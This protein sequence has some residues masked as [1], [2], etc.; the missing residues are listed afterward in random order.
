METEAAAN[1]NYNNMSTMDIDFFDEALLQLLANDDAN[2]FT[3]HA[4]QNGE[5]YHLHQI[6]NQQKQK[7]DVTTTTK[8]IHPHSIV[9]TVVSCGCETEDCSHSTITTVSTNAMTASGK[10]RS[11]EDFDEEQEED[12]ERQEDGEEKIAVLTDQQKAIG[13]RERNREHAKR[14]RK[15]KKVYVDTLQQNI[16][17]L[18]QENEKLR[19]AMTHHFGS[20]YVEEIL[21]SSMSFSSN[22]VGSS[23]M[24]PSITPT[25]HQLTYHQGYGGELSLKSISPTFTTATTTSTTTDN[26][27]PVVNLSSV[28]GIKHN[29]QPT[30]VTSTATTTTASPNTHQKQKEISVIEHTLNEINNNNIAYK[31]RLH[32]L[33]PRATVCGDLIANP[34]LSD[35]SL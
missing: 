32:L 10:K 28:S 3:S 21:T 30:I 22:A 33:L 23:G 2:P 25:M 18:Q 9:G 20:R 35:D 29:V 13:R 8:P 17:K 1:A 6:K 11:R 5:T 15:R 24:I 14:S 34:I 4:N 7:V 12:N 19:S 31:H 26:G 27:G 16:L